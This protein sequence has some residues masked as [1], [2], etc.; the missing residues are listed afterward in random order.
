MED[1]VNRININWTK[2]IA[3]FEIF[4]GLYGAC[5][6][7]III[8][9]KYINQQQYNSFAILSLLPFVLSLIAG[10]FLWRR[11]RIGL[12]LSI[13]LQAIQTMQI[14]INKLFYLFYSGLNFAIGVA[15]DKFGFDL[16]IGSNFHFL[17]YKTGLPPNLMRINLFAIFAVIYLL[18][19][20][21]IKNKQK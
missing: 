3:G 18:R 21:N 1:R 10:I 8:L 2:I 13:I 12:N 17:Y 14:S 16:A 9:N 6:T 7:I 20:K 4:G 15:G 11:S 19:M 5:F